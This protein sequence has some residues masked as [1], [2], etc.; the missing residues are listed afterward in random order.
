[1]NSLLALKLQ[2]TS[3]PRPGELHRE[4]LFSCRPAVPS[5]GCRRGCCGRFG[6]CHVLPCSRSCWSYHGSSSS[7]TNS[8]ILP[9]LSMGVPLRPNSQRIIKPTEMS[10]S[11]PLFSWN[12]NPLQRRRRRRRQEG[13]SEQSS[14]PLPGAAPRQPL[15]LPPSP[16]VSLCLCQ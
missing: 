7:V 11:T 13:D 9:K 4:P 6:R 16:S 10:P 12:N 8:S 3:L 14:G 5:S 15:F 2:V 1:M